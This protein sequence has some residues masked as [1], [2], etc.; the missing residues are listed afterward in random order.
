MRMG[1]YW[2]VDPVT[3][4]KYATLMSVWEAEDRRLEK[5]KVGW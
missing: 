2:V 1:L 5:V 4:M 3:K